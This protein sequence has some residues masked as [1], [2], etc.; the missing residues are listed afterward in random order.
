MRMKKIICLLSVCAVL[1]ASVSAVAYASFGS[2]DFEYKTDFAGFESGANGWN[3]FSFSNASRIGGVVGEKVDDFHGTS[4]KL[5]DLYGSEGKTGYAID[6]V[7]TVPSVISRGSCVL[8]FEIYPMSRTAAHLT[9]KA[10]GSS[11]E[12][13]YLITIFGTNVK[14]GGRFETDASYNMSLP[15]GSWSKV[16]I[17]MD[18][19]RGTYKTYI[20]GQAVD[21]ERKLNL[22]GGFSGVYFNTTYLDA[23][24]HGDFYIDNLCVYKTSTAINALPV[25]YELSVKSD[26]T[27]EVT[28]SDNVD[29]LLIS[30]DNIKLSFQN[31]KETAL[32]IIDTSYYGFK[33]SLPKAVG[34]GERYR[35]SLN[36]IRSLGGMQLTKNKLVF[37]DTTGI[38]SSA[39]DGYERFE[40]R[41]NQNKV[42]VINTAG[43]SGGY[44]L[45]VGYY[46]NGA[47][48]SAKNFFGTASE[49]KEED[50]FDIPQ[51]D[52]CEARAFI[53]RDNQSNMFFNQ[54]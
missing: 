33:F 32:N 11:G 30:E 49:D 50:I 17:Y 53:I 27:A 31:G 39:A 28:F 38:Y 18:I 37:P 25:D 34:S 46:R 47:M 4:M 22:S 26:N 21:A 54:Q 44:T 6:G 9:M 12:G 40:A 13:S 51:Y 10:K 48:V 14:A 24:N 42:S 3:G 2:G 29:P 52:G 7:V 16:Q 35:I 20:N 43:I 45:V 19:D 41:I 15:L 5:V 1:I 36:N 23:A 8:E